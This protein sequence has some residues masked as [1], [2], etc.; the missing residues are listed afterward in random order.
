MLYIFI[1]NV[2]EE[3]MMNDIKNYIKNKKYKCSDVSKRWP[4]GPCPSS[5]KLS[6]VCK[7][8]LFLNF[9]LIL[10]YYF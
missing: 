1:C 4:R 6:K 5:L 7:F 2:I 8:K 3:L 9:Y 10:F